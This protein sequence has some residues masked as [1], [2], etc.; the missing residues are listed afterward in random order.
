MG[1]WI[2][3]AALVAL[4]AVAI[5]IFDRHTTIAIYIL[6]FS[7]FLIGAIVGYLSR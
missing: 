3:L 2:A 6:I 1:G 4:Y 5:K 7:P